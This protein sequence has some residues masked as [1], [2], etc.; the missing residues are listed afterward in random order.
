MNLNSIDQQQRQ[1]CTTGTLTLD[2]LGDK[3]PKEIGTEVTPVR[4]FERMQ[5]QNTQ[6]ST[7]VV[8]VV[9]MNIIKVALSHC[10]CKTTV[11]C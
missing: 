6:Q 11:Q 9:E 1:Q 3:T 7:A 10:C 8:L 5:L 4:P 2:T